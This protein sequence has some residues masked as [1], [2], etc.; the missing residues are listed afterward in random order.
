MNIFHY[1]LHNLTYLIL[2]SHEPRG[3]NKDLAENVLKRETGDANKGTKPAEKEV[4]LKIAICTSS[5]LICPSL[6]K[7]GI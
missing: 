2:Y 6:G 7:I 1:L 3:R 5:H 4:F